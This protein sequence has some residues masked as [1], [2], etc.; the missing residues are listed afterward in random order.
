MSAY[1]AAKAGVEA[2]SDCVRIEMRPLGVDVG[3]AY[4]LFLDTD[5]VRD[6]ERELP[7]ADQVKNEVPSLFSRTYPLLPAID[8]V[9]RAIEQRRRRVAYPPWFLR[10]LPLRQV[11]ASAWLERMAAKRVQPAMEAYERA[12]AEHGA[13]AAAA[14]TRTREIAGL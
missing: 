1:C 14:A 8:Q 5:M 6:A 3:V 13:E 11:F 10:L 2:V 7:A 12:V 4:F 9:V